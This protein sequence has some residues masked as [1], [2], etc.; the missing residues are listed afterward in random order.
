MVRINCAAAAD[1]PVIV[2][3]CVVSTLTRLVRHSRRVRCIAAP[4]ETQAA[5]IPKRGAI[6]GNNAATEDLKWS[7]AAAQE[8][9]TVLISVA[10][11]KRTGHERASKGNSK[12]PWFLSGVLVT[13]PPRAKSLAIGMAKYPLTAPNKSERFHRDTQNARRRNLS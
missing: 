13:L 8:G 6:C 2:S 3:T 4:Q 9:K 1:V 10:P 12:K 7:A 5:G 11:N